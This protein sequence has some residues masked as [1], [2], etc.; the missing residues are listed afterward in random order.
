[1]ILAIW[2]YKKPAAA[3]LTALIFFIVVHVSDAIVEPT[4]LIKGILL[5]ILVLVALIKGY[6]DAREYEQMKK[7]LGIEPQ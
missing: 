3:F 5:K 4:Q 6:K 1:L 7:T 2:S